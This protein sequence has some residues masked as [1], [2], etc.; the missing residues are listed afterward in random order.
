MENQSSSLYTKLARV[1]GKVQAVSEDQTH[2]Q[3]WKYAGDKV[4]YNA[5]RQHL[6]E[7]GVA[8]I[9]SIESVQDNGTK[10]LVTLEIKLVCGES[11]EVMSS[12]WAAES[13]SKDDKGVNKC[14]TVAMKYFLKTTFLIATGNPD[15]DADSNLAPKPGTQQ[16]SRPSES[17][18]KAN[19]VVA[20]PQFAGEA[21]QGNAPDEPPATRATLSP[22]KLVAHLKTK[23]ANMTDTPI[24]KDEH[25]VIL[26]IP[27]ED[28]KELA[29]DMETVMLTKTRTW[30]LTQAFN[31]ATCKD[32]NP[33]EAAAIVAWLKDKPAARKD[34]EG[35]KALLE[36]LVEKVEA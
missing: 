29:R 18:A 17:P 26:P 25:G 15:D 35:V 10:M 23:A 34:A 7:E 30:I 1:M 14:A 5:V 21:L 4:I 22:D 31:T 36:K 13:F 11:G 6:A 16:K 20:P 12:K 19:N 2:G 33:R 28:A 27:V 24:T 3:G 9:P 8:I 32:L